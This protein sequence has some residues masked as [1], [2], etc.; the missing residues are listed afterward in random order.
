MKSNT[1]AFEYITKNALHI[2]YKK[3]PKNCEKLPNLA[4]L[5]K[6]G[7]RC[8]IKCDKL[9]N[10]AVVRKLSPSRNTDLMQ[11]GINRKNCAKK[12]E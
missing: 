9:A 11:D 6:R 3:F 4:F 8:T 2:N 10:R 12:M 1:G 7:N 5:T